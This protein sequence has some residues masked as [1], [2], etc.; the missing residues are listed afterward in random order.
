MWYWYMYVSVC[1]FITRTSFYLPT[2]KGPLQRNL[3]ITRGDECIAPS[4]FFPSGRA[5]YWCCRVLCRCCTL[6]SGVTYLPHLVSTTQTI[7]CLR[8]VTKNVP[9]PAQ[10]YSTAVGVL[11]QGLPSV[12]QCCARATG[13]KGL[14]WKYQRYRQGIFLNTIAALKTPFS[15]ALQVHCKSNG[16]SQND[17]PSADHKPN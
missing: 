16:G 9:P 12:P 15:S 7:I 8:L 1:C 17:E 3:H 13:A 10:L 11:L 14:C 2:A 6:L 4:T 5:S